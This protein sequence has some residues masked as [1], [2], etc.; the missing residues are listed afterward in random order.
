LKSKWKKNSSWK[1]KKAIPNSNSKD[2]NLII[3]KSSRLQN[4]KAF[5]QSSEKHSN[6]KISD[7]SGL[8]QANY[9]KTHNP[10]DLNSILSDKFSGGDDS[11]SQKNKLTMK[12]QKT[13][14]KEIKFDQQGTLGTRKAFI[15]NKNM[16]PWS[17]SAVI[18]LKPMSFCPTKCTFSSWEEY[19]KTEAEKRLIKRKTEPHISIVNKLKFGMPLFSKPEPAPPPQKFKLEV[20]LKEMKKLNNQKAKKKEL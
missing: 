2:E 15:I 5:T 3:Q 20:D 6:F 4:S 11:E 16:S 9:N 7:I 13:V 14:D 18:A 8:E 19:Q 17:E 12:V 10:I 1:Q